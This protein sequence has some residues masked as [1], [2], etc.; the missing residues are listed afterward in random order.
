MTHIHWFSP[1]PPDRTDIGHFTARIL[2]AL[3]ARARVILWTNTTKADVA[4]KSFAEIREFGDGNVASADL[5]AADAV[6]Y[7][8]GNHGPFHAAI[9]EQS[10]RIP[11]IVILHEADLHG[12]IAY[13]FVERQRRGDLYLREMRRA[14]GQAGA[15]IA[16]SRLDG[17]DVSRVLSTMPLLAA[18][19]RNC[20]GVIC[21]SEMTRAAVASLGVPVVRAE[22]PY[23]AT[24]QERP[25]RRTGP[26]RLVQFGYLNPYRRTLEI[27]DLLAQWRHREAVRFDIY[28]QLWDETLVRTRISALGLHRTVTVHGFTDEKVLDR[29]LNNADLVLNLRFPTLGEASGSQLRLWNAAVPSVV[30]AL[31]WFADLPGD[32]VVKLSPDRQ[33]EELSA[34][35][36]ALVADRYCFDSIGRRGRQVLQQRH[37]PDVYADVIK[38]AVDEVPRL[39]RRAGALAIVGTFR[40]RANA[41]LKG[42]LSVLSSPDTSPHICDLFLPPRAVIERSMSRQSDGNADL[43]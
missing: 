42:P 10:W 17:K 29:A 32:T 9:L 39:R 24:P 13:E 40:K 41:A 37:T 2:E 28:G 21:H 15:E 14:H 18:A 12:L 30:P 1:L 5:N 22:L 6:F 36:E 3:S 43:P 11:G 25:A 8:L 7:N 35:L 20:L 19:L 26:I 4:L 16:R 31:G 38:R 27:L 33:I 23:R 34:T